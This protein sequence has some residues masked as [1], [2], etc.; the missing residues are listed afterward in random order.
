MGKIANLKR[1]ITD[2]KFRFAILASHGFLRGMNDR[3]FIEKSYFLTTGK[4][5]NLDEPKT[6]NDKINW[7]KLNHRDPLLTTMVDKYLVKKYVADIIG[8]EYII[9]TLG[10]WDKF[11][12]IDFDSLPNQFVLKCTH[13]SGGLV[14]CKD[15]SKFNFKSAKKK[16]NKSLKRNYYDYVREWPY[17][18]VKPRIIAEKF[19]S[20]SSGGL[21]DYKTYNINGK[22]IMTMVC[23]DRHTGETKFYF[24]SKDWKHLVYTK[25]SQKK[26]D[27]M[28][29][30]PASIDKMSELAEKLAVGLPFA[31]VDFY[32]VDGHPY[33]GEITFF[34]DGGTELYHND[35]FQQKYGE[36]I[37][38][39]LIKKVKDK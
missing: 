33:F 27:F 19:I 5:L 9:P 26:P 2:K 22:F 20:D 14:I 21:I 25:A 15:K 36:M 39:S 3:K 24:M 29:E 30:K 13:D 17:K 1:F 28:M 8:E 32:D 35:E 34:S 12:D 10:V 23:L 38:L 11:E 6:Y 37:D 31:R 7:I 18:N 16:I 4:K